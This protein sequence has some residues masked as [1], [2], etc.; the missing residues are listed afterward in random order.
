[1]TARQILTQ[2]KNSPARHNNKSSSRSGLLPIRLL[3]PKR[4]RKKPLLKLIRNHRRKCKRKKWRLRITHQKMLMLKLQEGVHPWY[5]KESWRERRKRRM[6]KSS[7]QCRVKKRKPLNWK[8]LQSE[9]MSP[10]LKKNNI[11]RS[12]SKKRLRLL[13]KQKKRKQKRRKSWKLKS[14]SSLRNS[15][16]NFRQ[17]RL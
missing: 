7:G 14:S 16:K 17:Q 9:E 12:Q 5:L 15:R 8:K 6:K 1:M 4:L 13:K 2:T 11:L 3:L 10:G